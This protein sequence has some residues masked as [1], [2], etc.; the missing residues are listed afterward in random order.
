[1]R[2]ILSIVMLMSF[3]AQAHWGLDGLKDPQKIF[4]SLRDKVG[5]E[6]LFNN[7]YQIGETWGKER[8][9]FDKLAMGSE[10]YRKSAL[11]TFKVYNNFSHRGTAFY[12]GVYNGEHVVATNFHVLENGRGGT[13]CSNSYV[14]GL[15]LDHGKPITMKC[16]EALGM[17]SDVDFALFTI[18]VT[19]EQATLLDGIG[20]NLAFH[21]GVTAGLELLTVGFG[22]ANNPS[23]TMMANQ[24]AECLAFSDEVRYMADPDDL[25]PGDYKVWS[26]S[27]GCDISHGDS[28]SAM[29]DRNTGEVL[30]IIWT[31]RIPKSSKVRDNS[32]LEE[33]LKTQSEDIWKELSYAAPSTHIYKVLEQDLNSPKMPTHHKAILAE[34]LN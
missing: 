5:F 7:T 6:F 12:L 18:K 25:N 11:Q 34:I 10:V 33:I 26:F 3:G 1:M 20:Q 31:G 4:N 9:T 19:P 32:Y 13:I 2:F 16:K 14:E 21:R 30:G 28:G 27:N 23:Y 29:F 22:V 17:W 15:F 8:V 24:D